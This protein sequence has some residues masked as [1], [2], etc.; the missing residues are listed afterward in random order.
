MT[1]LNDSRAWNTGYTSL[2]DL[3]KYPTTGNCIRPPRWLPSSRFP[4]IGNPKKSRG[5]GS[6]KHSAAWRTIG[7]LQPGDRWHASGGRS[8]TGSRTR[9]AQGLGLGEDIAAA[10][11]AIGLRGRALSGFYARAPAR[12]GLVP[13][14]AAFDT[15]ETCARAQ[16]GSPRSLRLPA[17][18]KPLLAPVPGARMPPPKTTSM[19]RHP[20]PCGPG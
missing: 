13:G 9:G 2:S 20:S 11:A 4:W 8:G 7:D 18:P 12:Q 6:R 19:R 10:A 15:A 16:P 14:Y 3:L 17:A 5:L 1:H